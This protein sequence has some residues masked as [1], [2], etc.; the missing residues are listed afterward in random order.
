VQIYINVFSIVF[1]NWSA[2]PCYSSISRPV[3]WDSSTWK[4]HSCFYCN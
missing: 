3:F 1:N 2:S 4:V